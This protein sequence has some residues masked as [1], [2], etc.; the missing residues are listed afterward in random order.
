MN[1]VLSYTPVLSP[2][3][4]EHYKRRIQAQLGWTDPAIRSVSSQ[5]F[6]ELLEKD[7]ELRRLWQ[8]DPH[9]AVIRLRSL[10]MA[11]ALGPHAV[12]L[13]AH[14]TRQARERL[15]D[16]DSMVNASM[17]EYDRIIFG[18]VQRRVK[19]MR[20]EFPGWLYKRLVP[21]FAAD[22]VFPGELFESRFN[23][24]VDGFLADMPERSRKNRFPEA[25]EAYHAHREPLGRL[26]EEMLELFGPDW[27]D[28]D[29]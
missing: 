19:V 4:R 20:D 24:W 21:V 17:D 29:D 14:H 5:R 26:F 15:R 28:L 9:K 25:R 22:D 12:W 8:S 2:K 16:A 27:A 7:Q 13:C 10:E 18:N 6:E 23:E 3:Q 11:T 1:E